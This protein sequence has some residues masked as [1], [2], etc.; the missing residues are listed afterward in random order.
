MKPE[1]KY[2][3]EKCFDFNRFK[4]KLENDFNIDLYQIPCEEHGTKGI[5]R[6]TGNFYKIFDDIDQIFPKISPQDLYN[7]KQKK[8]YEPLGIPFRPYKY[9]E[10]NAIYELPIKYDS[11]EDEKK[12]MDRKNNFFSDM[13]KMGDLA[14]KKWSPETDKL[15]EEN[16]DFG[17]KSFEWLN[18]VLDKLYE[19]YPQYYVNNKLKIWSGE[20]DLNSEYD[21]PFEKSYILSELEFWLTDTFGVD[22]TGL[23][24]WILDC[25]FIEGRYWD[26]THQY[27]IEDVTYTVKDAP[28]N[29]IKIN[30][31]FR[32]IFKVESM[33]IF[34]DYYKY[35]KER[36]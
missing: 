1:L 25:Q 7:E 3:V 8:Q 11:S 27:D 16:V 6:N 22:T 26:I 29:V 17:P 21:Y 28:D 18:I 9:V 15:Y 24:E 36:Y 5:P 10:R 35:Y 12:W 31:I 20:D 23:Y 33:P 13:R 30:E 4:E 14:G 32:Q 19:L 2:P 34:I